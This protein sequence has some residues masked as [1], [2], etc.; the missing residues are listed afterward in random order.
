M[1]SA[2]V[3]RV[4]VHPINEKDKWEAIAKEIKEAKEFGASYKETF[5]KLKK[6]VEEI[7]EEEI[8]EVEEIIKAQNKKGIEVLKTKFKNKKIII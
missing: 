2:Q 1:A 6:E 7:S 8:K 5:A 4:I 3:S